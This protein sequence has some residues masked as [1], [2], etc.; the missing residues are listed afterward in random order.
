MAGYNDTMIRQ[1]YSNAMPDKQLEISTHVSRSMPISDD[2]KQTSGMQL[3]RP[4][5]ISTVTIE[6]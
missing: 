1:I 5:P 3:T 2:V 6:V 4:A